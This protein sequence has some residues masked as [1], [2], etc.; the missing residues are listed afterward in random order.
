MLTVILIDEHTRVLSNAC[1]KNE[2]I[3]HLSALQLF[4]FFFSRKEARVVDVA[5]VHID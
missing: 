4:Q 1:L 5:D 2:L 3:F